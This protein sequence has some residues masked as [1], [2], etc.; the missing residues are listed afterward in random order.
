MPTEQERPAF[1]ARKVYQGF[2][3]LLAVYL[4]VVYILPRPADVKPEGWRLTGIFIATVVGSIMEPIPAGALVLIAVTLSALTGSLTIE[5]AL[6][7]YADKSVWL[8]I[9]AFLISS[10]L[11]RTGMARRI[12]LVFVRQFGQTSLGV[13]YALGFSDAM[14]AG[15]IPS[16]AARCGGV[17]LPIIRAIAELYGSHPGDTAALLGSFLM[18]GVYQAVVI[19]CAMFLTGQA[20][21]PLAANI[22][23]QNGYPIT[24]AS[25]LQATIVPGVA[26][27]LI[28]P[29]VVLKINKPIITHTPEAAAFASRELTAMGKM[30]RDAWITSVVF[31]CVCALWITSSWT[32]I[33]ITVSALMGG[34]ALL[35]TGVLTWEDVKSERSAWDIFV[36]YGGLLRLGAALNEAG[37]TRAFA[38]AVAH[39]LEN[40][41]WPVLFGVALV[42]YFY[43]HYGFASITAHILSMFPPF[44]AILLAK[45]APIGM[46]VFAFAC[47]ANLGA[48]LTNYG[49]TPTPMYFAQ[50]YVSLKKWWTIGLLASFVNLAVWGV[51]G[52]AWWKLIGIW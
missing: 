3:I 1:N 35:L 28:V 51:L 39:Q 17:T 2:G 42:I 45:G 43:A 19:G 36:W 52:L 16:S 24:W 50:G 8:V 46:V 15:M 4:F 11:I 14:M 18:T 25:W 33:D 20:S 40:F 41:G 21:N 23:A 6:L 13:A 7:G 5:Q 30:S 26:S 31:L 12:A 9:V 44:L 29:W 48:G 37:V 49:T 32:K 27:L 10:A 22:A 34:M 38:N 47:F